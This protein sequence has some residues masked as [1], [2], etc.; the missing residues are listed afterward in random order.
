[1]IAG[2]VTVALV[3]AA[4]AGA[5]VYSQLHHPNG[6]PQANGSS[7]APP[8]TTTPSPTP[9]PTPTEF[10]GDLRTLLL[11]PP[12]SSTPF[13]KP[14]TKDGTISQTYVTSEFYDANAAGD[15]LDRDEFKA[16]AAVQWHDDNDTEVTIEIY[17]FGSDRGASS[18][19]AFNLD[20]YK[21]DTSVTNI[22]PIADIQGSGLYVDKRAD[23]LGLVGTTGLAV[24]GNL[25]MIIYI[26][27]PSKQVDR[28]AATS[29]M[30]HQY[31]QLP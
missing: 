1:V 11:T 16:G 21:G 18:W 27:Q 10:T 26:Y 24:K 25:Y 20:G 28:D 14:I 3:V 9:S 5:A 7:T 29:I 12:S 30:Q 6:N 13:D 15:E 17:R 8:A 22:S 23:N 31:Q 2:V 4:A 19:L